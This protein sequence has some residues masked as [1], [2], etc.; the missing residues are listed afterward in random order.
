[1]PQADFRKIDKPP[2]LGPM[3]LSA[4][5]NNSMRRVTVDGPTRPLGKHYASRTDPTTSWLTL[6]VQRKHLLNLPTARL[7]QIALDLSPQVGKG[8]FDFLRFCNPGWM[9]E[10]DTQ[11]GRRVVE[12]FIEEL[13]VLHGSFDVLLDRMFASMFVGG[14][15]FMELVLNPEGTDALNI[16]V[17]D[18]VLARYLRKEEPGL[19]QYWQLTQKAP[20]GMEDIILQGNPRIKYVGLDTLPDNPYGRPMVTPSVYASI[21]LLGLIQDV[22]R[23]IANQGFARLDYEVSTEEILKLIEQS[24]EGLVGDD[25]ATAAFIENHLAQIN[26]VLERLDVESSYVHLDT[27]KV[28]YAVS[29]QST[30]MP[31][32]DILVRTLERQIT[33]GLKSIPILMGSNESTAET[34][35]NRQLDFYIAAIESIQDGLAMVLTQFFH[36][37]LQVRGVYG[38][39]KFLFRRQR[40]ID[41]KTVADTEAVVIDN[42]VKKLDA[43]L[44]TLEQAQQEA[45]AMADPLQL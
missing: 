23:V 18:P 7:I 10:A 45:S 8:L 2:T 34:H 39:V 31:G 14:A 5:S 21:F 25:E 4:L 42:I 11:S 13:G 43:E 30:T 44:I 1:M 35:A 17:L 20:Q 33:N 9:I 22:R 36:M 29:G 19:G 26:A 15:Y 6:E 16:A 40:I 28:N 3:S 32:L 41:R 24:G 27:V 38:G 12:G 37:L